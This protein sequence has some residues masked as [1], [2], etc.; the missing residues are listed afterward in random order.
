MYLSFEY[1]SY[2]KFI[3]RQRRSVSSNLHRFFDYKGIFSVVRDFS[4]F[5]LSNVAEELFTS[6]PILLCS[7]SYQ[8]KSLPLL[9]ILY[10]SALSSHKSARFLFS[11]R[12]LGERSSTPWNLQGTCHSKSG[13]LHNIP[14]CPANNSKSHSTL[15]FWRLIR[16]IMLKILWVSRRIY[17]SLD[18]RKIQ[19]SHCLQYLPV[20]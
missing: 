4:L 7:I 5:F 9:C 3:N 17:N 20:I 1:Q 12:W 8:H 6:P 10:S 14:N 19:F 13:D 2:H 18:I 11:W 15:E 16:A